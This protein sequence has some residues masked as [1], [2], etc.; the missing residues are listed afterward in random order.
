MSF[1]LGLAH[2]AAVAFSFGA[3][4]L[5]QKHRGMIVF[6]WGALLCAL[7]M[8]HEISTPIWRAMPLLAYVQF[9]WRFLLLAAL[10]ASVIAGAAA[11]WL[12]ELR[13][14][15][16]WIGPALAGLVVA[17]PLAVY[18][19]YT[20]SRQM[21][22]DTVRNKYPRYD[23]AE[24]RKR[25]KDHRLVRLEKY[26][27]PEEIRNHSINATA[28]EDYLPMTVRALP[29]ERA[30]TDVMAAP[31][32]VVG[33]TRVGPRRYEASVRMDSD[34]GVALTRFWHPGWR[35][36]V[37][38]RETPTS[39]VGDAGLAA[40]TVPAG[41]HAVRFAFVGLP[42]WRDAWLVSAAGVA[43]LLVT[44]IVFRRREPTGPTSTAAS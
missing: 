21:L 35:A 40:V 19:P 39:P 41:E 6:W 2:W 26:F 37:D 14:R 24:I 22:Y 20:F 42:R 8:C 29:R 9:P 38:G 32:Q 31:G 5:W 18:F 12:A 30:P 16:R 4:A 13:F 3:F 43:L 25:L 15:W 34:G 10:A 44:M 28:R 11:Q 27:T 33:F 1:Q 23:A 36:W 17:A 7:A